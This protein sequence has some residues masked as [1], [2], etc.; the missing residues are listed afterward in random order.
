MADLTRFSKWKIY[1]TAVVKYCI[2]DISPDFWRSITASKKKKKNENVFHIVLD[3][4]SYVLSRHRQKKIEVNKKCPNLCQKIR[5]AF[6][7]ADYFTDC[8]IFIDWL[9]G[10]LVGWL[11]VIDCDWLWL[12]VIDCDW[13]WLIVIDCDWLWLIVIDCDWLWLIVID[14][15]WLWLIVIDCDWLWLI[16]GWL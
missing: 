8:I 5:D 7:K 1:S 4:V 11:I 10:W 6:G 3:L 2:Y 14:C 9:V 13:L 12:I 16:D 15:D